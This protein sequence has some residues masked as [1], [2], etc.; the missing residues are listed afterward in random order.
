[1]ISALKRLVNSNDSKTAEAS[2]TT[3]QEAP[4]GQLPTQNTGSGAF[5]NNGMHTISQSLQKKFSRGVNYNMKV[6]IR[7]DNNVGK[8]S[9]WL[10]LQGQAFKEAYETSEEI[11][12]ANI[13]WNYKT[14]DDIVKVEVW[15]VVD[16]SKKKKNL[17]GGTTYKQKNGFSDPYM[18]GSGG[19]EASLDA[20]FIDVYKSANGCIMV[21]DITKAWTWDYIERELPKIPAHIPV[22]IIG[23]FVD[24]KHHRAVD[25]LKCKYFLENLERGSLASSIRYTEASM[26]TGFGLKYLYKFFN[27]PFLQLQR[28]N[29][30]QQLETNAKEM[31]LISEELTEHET[32]NEEEY[33]AFSDSLNNLRRRDAELNARDVLKNAKSVDEAR[34][35]AAQRESMEKAKALANATEPEKMINN[36]KDKINS[37]VSGTI[38]QPKEK[39]PVSMSVTLDQDKLKPQKKLQTDLNDF[40]PQPT[41]D[42][43]NQFLETELS[44]SNSQNLN[45]QNTT[46][47]IDEDEPS[48]GNP[49]VAGFRDTIDSDDDLETSSKNKPKINEKFFELS[50]EEDS[51][52]GVVPTPSS[53]NSMPDMVTESS[54]NPEHQI[55]KNAQSLD[56]SSHDFDFLENITNNLTVKPTLTSIE[57]STKT[58]KKKKPKSSKSL[59]VNETQEKK[60]S[61]SKGKSKDKD[62]E[63]KKEKKS[64]PVEGSDEDIVAV[65]KDLD[66]EE[67]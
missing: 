38:L 35:S 56:L 61:K 55:Q 40:L 20:E 54:N 67:I 5:S 10:R 28:E 11:K 41:E 19:V 37:T 17:T 32:K 53:L 23:N 2:A 27:I 50:D 57:E 29:L 59:D 14:T 25:Q 44:Q 26:R 12:V 52:L 39:A 45:K 22:L 65:K 62:R 1:M 15:D 47:D 13:Q 60:K 64:A 48:Q 63:R 8:S 18:L 24:V 3:T 42:D 33:E 4:E 16:R 46:S 49:M 21:Y 51:Q 9:L 31:D 58:S 6:V 34:K 7:G 36:L 66:Y 30:M 43:F